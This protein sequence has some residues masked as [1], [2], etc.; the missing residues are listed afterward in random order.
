MFIVQLNTSQCTD[1]KLMLTPVALKSCGLGC[2]LHKCA[3]PKMCWAIFDVYCLVVPMNY[4]VLGEAHLYR[5]VPMNYSVPAKAHLCR[6]QSQSVSH[7][8]GGEERKS[9][10]GEKILRGRRKILAASSLSGK[11]WNCLQPLL[12]HI[13]NQTRVCFA[14]SNIQQSPKRRPTAKVA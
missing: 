1:T 7:A 11:I 12:I 6:V 3:V 10:C 8:L 14:F 9:W 4:S 2:T 5:L 13:C